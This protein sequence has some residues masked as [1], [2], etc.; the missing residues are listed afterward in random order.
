MARLGIYGNGHTYMC[1]HTESAMSE[2]PV[3][4]DYE[5]DEDLAED[6]ASARRES[7]RSRRES[8]RSSPRKDSGSSKRARSRSR[9]RY[10]VCRREE[11][12]AGCGLEVGDGHVLVSYMAE[13]MGL[14]IV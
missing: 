6:G 3:E 11:R 4:L 8:K 7:T 12:G 2:G 13:R 14:V 5:Y 10:V 1:A 9:S